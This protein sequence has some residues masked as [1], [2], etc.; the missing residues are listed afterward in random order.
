MKNEPTVFEFDPE[1]KEQITRYALEKMLKE[2]KA[3]LQR[4][5]RIKVSITVE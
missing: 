2:I 1:K 4:D 3:H 5:K